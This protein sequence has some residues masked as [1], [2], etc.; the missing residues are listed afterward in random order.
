MNSTP[1][2]I[3]LNTAD[4]YKDY[5]T[6]EFCRQ[7]VFTADGIRV[8][9]SEGRFWHAFCTRDHKGKKDT[10][11]FERAQYIGWIRPTL[12]HPDALLLKGWNS[13]TKRTEPHRRVSVV[14][15]DFVVVLE[16]RL[17]GTDTLKANFVTA[18]YA[19]RSIRR[20]KASPTWSKDECLHYLKGEKND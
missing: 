18:F 4:E 5:Y 2:I 7:A 11:S 17:K 16:L 1:P 3:S 19:D 13:T 8:Y 6:N 12:E 20:V 10:F 9:F 14:Y 15:E